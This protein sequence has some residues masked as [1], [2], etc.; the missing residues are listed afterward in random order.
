MAEI[1]CEGRASC[2]KT[3]FAPLQPL[4][5]VAQHLVRDELVVP[6]PTMTAP[7]QPSSFKQPLSTASAEGP[8]TEEQRAS[9]HRPLACRF[10]RDPHPSR[11][12]A[13]LAAAQAPS[14]RQ[15]HQ[16]RS[17]SQGFLPGARAH[18]HR[19]L[20]PA[21]WIHHA[22]AAASGPPG[23]VL[24]RCRVPG[25]EPTACASPRLGGASK[26]GGTCSFF[27]FWR[28][29]RGKQMKLGLPLASPPFSSCCNQVV[30]ILQQTVGESQE[31]LSD[32][33][34][35]SRRALVFYMSVSKCE[36]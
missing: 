4:A 19:G 15:S 5:E 11:D 3:C 2:S 18:R 9:S 21:H 13:A 34:L 24:P 30:F 25:D 33:S 16:H 6:R 8:G 32:S 22:A 14:T 17:L 23:T 26:P 28:E 36:L 10:L 12:A 27:F 29:N 7:L 20:V 1:L 35:A 31:I